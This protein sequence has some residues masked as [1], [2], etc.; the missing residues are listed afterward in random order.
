MPFIDCKI[1]KK[2][3]DEQKEKLK[4][5]LGES[6]A[7]IGKIESYLMVGINDGYSLY[8]AG[9]KVNNGAYIEVSLYGSA[10][11]NSYNKMTANICS[12]LEKEFNLSPAEVYVTY[13]PVQDWGWDGQNF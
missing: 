13:H 3:T 5:K 2:L 11:K 7:I 4:S 6:V 12:L 8:F 10:S 1:T 9:K